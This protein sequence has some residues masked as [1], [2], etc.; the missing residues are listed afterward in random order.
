MKG[1]PHMQKFIVASLVILLVSPVLTRADQ[2]SNESTIAIAIE[3]EITSDQPQDNNHETLVK[4]LSE[5]G[6]E[7]N[8]ELL[9]ALNNKNTR[10]KIIKTSGNGEN[11]SNPSSNKKIF[12]TR[13]NDGEHR[14]RGSNVHQDMDHLNIEVIETEGD[15]LH[16]I[17]GIGGPTGH[18]EDMLEEVRLK[19]IHGEAGMTPGAMHW[20]EKA[21]DGHPMKQK[22]VAEAAECI[23]KNLSKVNSSVAAKL[24]RE[25][26]ISLNKD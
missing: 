6:I 14:A 8:D 22:M 20:F 3:S 21:R 15:T 18:A 2:E 16:F 17:K 11:H 25:A 13:S 9:K 5:A 7:L 1:Y 19:E 26:C 23:I 10:I 12:V 4:V 24:L